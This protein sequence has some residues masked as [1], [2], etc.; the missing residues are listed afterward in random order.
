MAATY[1][2]VTT[3]PLVAPSS[4]HTC[5]IDVT[6]MM[7]ARIGSG[8]MDGLREEECVEADAKTERAV[9]S[10][11]VGV[12][13]T[14]WTYLG[15]GREGR[16]HRRTTSRTRRSCSDTP[17]GTDT[18]RMS[19]PAYH[20]VS[21]LGEGG[22]HRRTLPLLDCGIRWRDSRVRDPRR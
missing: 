12:G 19:P 14:L 11:P 17:R 10:W 9:V 18:I 20:S 3:L 6:H 21:S 4:S 5:G 15:D 16:R 13:A 1:A 7:D 2:G 22:C 8:R